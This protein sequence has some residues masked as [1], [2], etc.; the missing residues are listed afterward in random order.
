MILETKL[1]DCLS[2]FSNFQW[3]VFV[4]QPNLIRI[5]TVAGFFVMSEDISAIKNKYIIKNLIEAL[6]NLIDSFFTE[7]RIESS[8]RILC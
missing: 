7:I 5:T 8:E 2:L 6:K 3:K 4:H 1:D